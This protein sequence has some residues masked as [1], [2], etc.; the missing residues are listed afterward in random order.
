MKLIYPNETLHASTILSVDID[1]EGVQS[2]THE[3]G[4]AVFGPAEHVDNAVSGS[5]LLKASQVGGDGISFAAITVSEF[6]D[7]AVFE[8]PAANLQDA[9]SHFK[10]YAE[11]TEF[12]TVADLLAGY[13][14]FLGGRK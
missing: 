1:C 4:V 11:A 12:D 3:D 10:D 14:E 5:Y 7:I 8:S 13:E 6:N 2:I 9:L